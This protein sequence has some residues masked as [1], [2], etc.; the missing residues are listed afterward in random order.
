MDEDFEIEKSVQMYN[1]W[2]YIVPVTI[3]LLSVGLLLSFFDSKTTN[4]FANVIVLVGILFAFYSLYL[5][6]LR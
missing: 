4:F 2:K 6:T 3:V 1:T 5:F